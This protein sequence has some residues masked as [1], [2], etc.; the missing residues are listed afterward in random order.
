MLYVGVRAVRFR[1]DQAL[2]A[3]PEQRV[4]Q[5]GLGLVPVEDAEGAARR[6][7]V[8]RDGRRRVVLP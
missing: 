1:E 5:E 4:Q 6:P 8:G 3:T 7:V 2:Q